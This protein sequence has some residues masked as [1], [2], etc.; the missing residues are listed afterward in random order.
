MDQTDDRLKLL[1]IFYYVMAAMAALISCAAIL[2]GWLGYMMMFHPEQM[3]GTGQGQAPPA[4]MGM[5]FVAAGIVSFEMGWGFA[6]CESLVGRFL[7]A[8]KNRMFCLVIACLNFM[9]APLGTILGVFTIVILMQP[10]VKAQFDQPPAPP[11]TISE[12]LGGPEGAPPTT[13]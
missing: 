4:F 10:E 3:G 11:A 7:R 6:V 13:L 8:R 12:P 9:N 2:W 5:I 1:A